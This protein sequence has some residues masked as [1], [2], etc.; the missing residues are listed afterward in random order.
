[1]DKS[2]ILSIQ[3]YKR[4]CND[5]VNLSFICYFFLRDPIKEYSVNSI[6]KVKRYWICRV[7][8]SVLAGGVK[9]SQVSRRL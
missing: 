8:G 5:K 3:S 4:L 7:Q 6:C 2:E 1:M 9:S